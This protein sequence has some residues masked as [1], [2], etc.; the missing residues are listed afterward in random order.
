MILVC[1]CMIPTKRNWILALG[2]AV[3]FGLPVLSLAQS[4]GDIGNTPI[5][6]Q[7]DDGGFTPTGAAGSPLSCAG[8]D[9]DPNGANLTAPENTDAA[10]A[11]NAAS[12]APVCSETGGTSDAPGCDMAYRNTKI[13][14]YDTYAATDKD[15]NAVQLPSMLFQSCPA[16]P[17]PHRDTPHLSY[18]KNFSPYLY[19]WIQDTTDKTHAYSG[20]VIRGTT[21]DAMQTLAAIGTPPSGV[22]RQKACVNQIDLSK[23][24]TLADRAKLI[25]LQLDNCANQFILNTAI[26]PN[27]KAN[28]NFICGTAA[29]PYKHCTQE[30]MCQPL[31]T[32]PDNNEYLPSTYITAAWKKLLT[33]PSSA[34]LLRNGKA[35]LEPHLPSTLTFTSTIDVPNFGEIRTSQ[36]AI[37]PYEE[38]IDP[39][40]PF[41]PRWDF[42]N[43][44]RDKYSPLT[45]DYS[46]DAKNAV[47]C[48]GSKTNVYKVDILSFREQKLDFDKKVTE[49]I[50][51]NE[52]C[53]T[54]GGM[55]KNP[56][57]YFDPVK[58]AAE[59]ALS[60]GKKVV[61]KC[62]FLSCETC[63][64]MTATQPVCATTYA[65]SPDR[66]KN[67]P[68]Y[69]S[70]INPVFPVAAIL[71]FTQTVAQLSQ[72]LS[73]TNMPAGTTVAQAASVLK[74]TTSVISAFAPN[75]PL[76]Q[77]TPLL[78]GQSS[79]LS[80]AKSFVSANVHLSVG[81]INLNVNDV[82]GLLSAPQ[83][84]LGGL[85]PDTL[86]SDAKN[87]LSGQVNL[88]ANFPGGTTVAQALSGIN[89]VKSITSQVSALGGSTTDAKNLMNLGVTLSKATPA[90]A[91][92][93]QATALYNEYGTK[94]ND[95]SPSTL[96]SS[97]DASKTSD[98]GKLLAALPKGTTVGQATTVFRA[99]I[100]G[101]GTIDSSQPAASFTSILNTT[102]GNA[103]GMPN[104][105]ITQMAKTAESLGTTLGNMA[106]SVSS[107]GANLG[108]L[109]MGSASTFLKGQVDAMVQLPGGLKVSTVATMLTSQSGLLSGVT[110]A[111][112][113]SS[114]TG[115]FTAQLSSLGPVGNM[116]ASAIS[117][118]MSSQ[119]TALTSALTS[120][121]TSA[122]TGGLT[123]A[124]GSSGVS[125]ALSAVG[126]GNLSSI[127]GA[128]D[129]QALG[130]GLGNLTSAAGL[131]NL[132]SLSGTSLSGLG[133]AGMKSVTS[134]LGSFN[135]A[136][137]S[138][139]ANNSS[140]PLYCVLAALPLANT[141]ASCN[142]DE[143]GAKND[144]AMASLCKDLRA[145][146]TP[147][148]KLKMRYHD[149]NDTASQVLKNGVLEGLSFNDYFADKDN[150]I[151]HMPYPRLWDTGRSI[152]NLQST[153][154][155]PNDIH[156]QYTSIVGVGR[157]AATDAVN[158]SLPADQ[159]H[160]DERCLYGGWGENNGSSVSFAGLSIQVPDPITSWTELKLYQAYTT[161]ETNVVCLG[162]YEKAFQHRSNEGQLLAS[163]AASLPRNVEVVDSKNAKG[164]LTST[165]VDMGDNGGKKVKTNSRTQAGPPLVL[166]PQ[167]LGYFTASD[168][169][170]RFPNLP[171]GGSVITG[172]DNAQCGD[173]IL[174]PTG[175]G[176]T[177]AATRGLPK[178]ARVLCPDSL[179]QKPNASG[180]N[181]LVGTSNHYVS[182]KEAD[183][184]RW[185]DVC[186]TTNMFGEL[187]QRDLYKPGE[188]KPETLAILN[189]LGWVHTCADTM[190]EE[191]EMT[192]WSSLQLYRPPATARTGLSQT[193]TTSTGTTTTGTTT[194]GTTTTGATTTGATTTG[195]TT[196]T[197]STTGASATSGTTTTG[198]TTTG[199]ASGSAV[200][201]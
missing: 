93:A 111:A 191:C 45:Q 6:T 174:M 175:G 48:A 156:G 129:A 85:S 73:L 76:N 178:I 20:Y 36:L 121:A 44:E 33:D 141:T 132:Q 34:S 54:N 195:T 53:H 109:D 3:T 170:Q 67:I 140:I 120:G 14:C 98:A 60:F 114:L 119:A 198:T 46:K 153:D 70:P 47:F 1:G 24:T 21:G 31:R 78:S 107:G 179:A 87:M 95:L 103:I 25:R 135:P 185:P 128:V 37:T 23:A 69:K 19:A 188:M 12:P 68:T 75:T 106:T 50:N 123:S 64:K 100:A 176:G 59:V 89:T 149:P 151:G 26:S 52:A 171:G 150:K 186:G 11:A 117:S 84:L 201:P 4:S 112:G 94:L 74:S 8:S 39:S 80:A 18:I 71:R 41:S 118:V 144:T 32:L 99:N 167:W 82:A 7:T 138:N 127:A 134:S 162:R 160:H 13:D 15:G 2:L 182:V 96:V 136:D 97:V 9:C 131:S 137:C 55:Q 49:R 164:I 196:G 101:L 145:P 17:M 29:N 35:P 143:F 169:S 159:Q 66:A 183:N 63:Y 22:T 154:Q 130:G 124:I 83:G 58:Y 10:A 146:Y 125:S 72:A 61:P 38:I 157:E 142:P 197:T 193:S 91:T 192:N 168:A 165:A 90:G 187:K 79:M 177:D 190:L 56:C 51:Y 27:Y 161:R 57:C 86:M 102:V 184:G 199:G 113:L 166:P 116:A 139:T 126:G 110:S 152:Q 194:T 181:L 43:N 65:Q 155:D 5:V 115:A 200:K 81:G 92:V 108:N 28:S 62:E 180:V 77:I 122:L 148:N 172:L 88:M 105:N 163:D 40:H 158:A 133:G 173:F 104:M 147:I 30:D 189:R 42:E 16:K